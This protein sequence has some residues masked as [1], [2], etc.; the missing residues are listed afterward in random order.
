[1]INLIWIVLL[2]ITLATIMAIT[3]KIPDLIINCI[4][5]LFRR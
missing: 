3:F 1:M 5:N 4:K 2:I